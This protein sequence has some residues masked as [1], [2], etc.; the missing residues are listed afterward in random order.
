LSRPLGLR[1]TPIRR[2]AAN[3]QGVKNEEQKPVLGGPQIFVGDYIGP[4]DPGNDPPFTSSSSP[5]WLNNFTWVPDAPVW[6][7]HGV[8]GETDM[9]GMYDLF[10]FGPV[11]GTIAFMMPNEWALQAPALHTFAVVL[12][13]EADPADDIITV[14]CQRIDPNDPDATVSDVPVRIYWP[15]CADLCVT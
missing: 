12:T 1:D 7:A 6:F 4:G 11:S 10:T 9:G 5:P 13:T 2:V 3:Q 14:A 8:D 15:L